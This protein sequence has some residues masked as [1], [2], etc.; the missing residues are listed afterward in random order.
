MVV[1][2]HVP[3]VAF[4]TAPGVPNEASQQPGFVAVVVVGSSG[5][6]YHVAARKGSPPSNAE[7]ICHGGTFRREG[8]E[9]SMTP[10]DNLVWITAVLVELSPRPLTRA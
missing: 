7:T 2:C 8:F 4:S 6:A 1:P 3:D 5:V 10:V 9:I